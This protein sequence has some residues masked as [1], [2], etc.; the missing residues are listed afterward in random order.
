MA[1]YCAGAAILRQ[2]MRRA[3]GRSSNLATA[4]FVD[5]QRLDSGAACL[6]SYLRALPQ[7]A[8]PDP[9]REVRWNGMI[10]GEASSS[11]S[12]D[13]CLWQSR[14]YFRARTSTEPADNPPDTQTLKFFA[15]RCKFGALAR[16]CSQAQNAAQSH[17]DNSY[18]PSRAYR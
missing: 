1:G 4:S 5:R 8:P 9:V 17:I 3:I 6:P 11:R 10:R 12:L 18:A 7:E 13:L 14:F 2:R 15:Q 16:I